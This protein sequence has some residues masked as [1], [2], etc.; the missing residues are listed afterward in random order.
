L[1]FFITWF[2]VFIIMRI[3]LYVTRGVPCKVG[4]LVKIT[5]GK[6]KGRAGTVTKCDKERAS[7]CVLLEKNSTLDNEEVWF[8]WFE[9]RRKRQ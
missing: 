2:P 8:D 3:I 9:I 6:H 7:V 1:G 5:A 4:Q